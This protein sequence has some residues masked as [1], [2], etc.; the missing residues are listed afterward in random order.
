MHRI[1][2]FEDIDAWKK[3]RELTK[4]IYE[5]TSQGDLSRE[6][7]LKD[8]LRRASISIMAEYCKR[9][10]NGKGI[11]SLSNFLP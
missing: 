3:A 1:N 8:Q 10:L 6:F 5:I 4:R 11:K 7:A 2:R 9:L